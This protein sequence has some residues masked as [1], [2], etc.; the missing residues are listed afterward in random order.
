M[1]YAASSN[2]VSHVWVAGRQVVR[3]GRPLTLDPDAILA[4]ARSW[5]V[6]IRES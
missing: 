2:Q 4:A 5:Q 3:D 1:V 6:R